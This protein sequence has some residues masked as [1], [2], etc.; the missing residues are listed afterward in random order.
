MLKVLSAIVLVTTALTVYNH[1][2][3]LLTFEALKTNR[4]FLDDFITTYPVLAG[5]MYSGTMALIIGLTIPGATMLS[6]TGGVLFRQPYAAICAYIGYVFGAAL[7]FTAVRYFLHGVCRRR[8]KN[9]PMFTKFEQNARRNA[10][11]YLILARYTMVFPFWFV[12][13]MSAIVAIPFGTFLSA[14]LVSVIPG[15]LV[16][17][18]AGRA[19]GN[20]LDRMDVAEISTWELV[21]EAL[22][23]PNVKICLISL[24]ACLTIAAFVARSDREKKPRDTEAAKTQ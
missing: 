4:A 21:K 18:T 2:G 24:A 20:M 6:F 12:N 10:F 3:H 17:T 23:D 22:F 19:L 5:T 16:Y 13:S 7:S 8:L 1:F 15:S 11:M 9:R 14:T